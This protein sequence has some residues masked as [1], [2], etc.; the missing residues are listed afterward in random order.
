MKF[1]RVPFGNR[2]SPFILNATVK[3]HLRQFECTHVIKE[4]E[5]N[6]YV[7]DWLTGADEHEEATHMIAEADAVIRQASMNLTKWGSNRK[8][9]LDEALFNMVDK[10][11]HLCNIKVLGLRWNPGE[12]CFVF[13][14]MPLQKGMIITKRVLLSLIARLFDPLGLL[15][16]FVIGLKCLF[17]EIWR[18]G[19]D[20]DS[21]VPEDYLEIASRWID[22]LAKVYTP[23]KWRETT[24]VNL[25]VFG[26]ASE[27]A[28]GACVYLVMEKEDG[29]KSSS[30]VL[31]KTKVAPLKR[32][33][34]PCLELLEALLAVQLVEFVRKDLMITKYCYF[35]WTDSMVVLG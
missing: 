28:Y 11:E 12:D 2:C 24:F 33:T 9:V 23:G 30:L 18:L 7:D 16:P 20:W 1:V 4:L 29:T 21:E 34:L 13:E 25:H 26:D 35:C 10:C 6:L 32:V 31:S 19:L 22:D 17:Q 8:E 5:D 27:K 3:Y 15:N 14:G